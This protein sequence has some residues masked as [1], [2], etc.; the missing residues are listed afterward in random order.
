MAYKCK[1]HAHSENSCLKIFTYCM[2]NQNVGDPFLAYLKHTNFQSQ[3]LAPCLSYVRY[4]VIN[5]SFCNEISVAEIV[6]ELI[7]VIL[8]E[9]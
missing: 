8:F 7:T 2:N 9:S 6:Q 4:L 3:C 1:I 5:N